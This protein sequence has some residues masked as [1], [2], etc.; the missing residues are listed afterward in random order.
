MQLPLIVHLFSVVL[1]QLV[2]NFF[3]NPVDAAVS[4]PMQSI[5]PCWA[6]SPPTAQRKF[7]QAHS[8]RWG[9]GGARTGPRS[10]MPHQQSA[11]GGYFV[12]PPVSSLWDTS[13]TIHPRHPCTAR[14][15]LTNGTE[16]LFHPRFRPKVTNHRQPTRTVTWGHRTRAP[17]TRRSPRPPSPP[18]VRPREARRSGGHRLR[19]HRSAAQSERDR[20]ESGSGAAQAPADEAA[21]PAA[22]R[23]AGTAGS[24]APR[25]RVA[26][27]RPPR[28]ERTPAGGRGAEPRPATH[29]AAPPPRSRGH[30]ASSPPPPGCRLHAPGSSFAPRRPP[31]AAPPPPRAHFRPRPPPLARSRA[32][33]GAGLRCKEMGG[34]RPDTASP[35]PLY[36]SWVHGRSSENSLTFRSV[37]SSQGVPLQIIQFRLLRILHTPSS[38]QYKAPD[39]TQKTSEKHPFRSYNVNESIAKKRCINPLSVSTRQLSSLA[40]SSRA[41]LFNGVTASQH[42]SVR[43]SAAG[44]NRNHSSSKKKGH[45]VPSVDYCSLSDH[46]HAR[47]PFFY[48]QSEYAIPLLMLL[49]LKSNPSVVGPAS[50]AATAPT[51]RAQVCSRSSA[52]NPRKQQS[53]IRWQTAFPTA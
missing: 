2:S 3:M 7:S 25:P 39:W 30:S 14:R 53:C 43:D 17:G 29:L 4:A 10:P 12:P 47:L 48:T 34:A 31:L 37:A 38:K 42:R 22:L 28:S 6:A 49:Q 5:S 41:W 15:T 45:L 20:A 26:T 19:P 46:L 11:A 40:L 8:Q 16:L 13:Q 35:A 18:I 36:F 27:P 1:L 23:P 9:A 44:A 24:A 32:G 50:I 33:R 21:P 51:L 52:G